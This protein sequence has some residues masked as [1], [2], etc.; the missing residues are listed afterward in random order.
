MIQ[1]PGVQDIPEE[2]LVTDPDDD[3]VSEPKVSIKSVVLP[4]LIGLGT[5]TV[6]GI[7]TFDPDAYR[8][9]WESLN[10]L[11]LA[12][13]AVCVLLRILFGGMRLSYVS[14]GRLSFTGGL[15]GQM[16]WDF[17]ANITPSLVGGAPLAAYYIA[18]SAGEA[19]GRKIK[20]GEVTAFMMFIMLL[21]QAWFALSVIPILISALFLEV[22]PSS[23]GTAGSL[24]A[25]IYFIGFMGWT[26]L[27]AYATFFRPSLL[28]AITDNICRLPFLRR[29]RDRVRHEMEEYDKRAAILR[30]QP[31]LF[32]VQGLGLTGLT[33]IA[34]Y[35][36]VVFIV[37]SFVPHVD[38]LLLFLRSMAMTIGT[39]IMPTPGGAGGVEGLYVLFFKSLM[40]DAFIAPTLLIW[41]ILGYYIFLGF[42]ILITTHHMHMR[43]RKRS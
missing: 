31:F 16:A 11:I 12:G 38:Q 14:R 6:I 9:M 27:F 30:Q 26:A 24:T 2:I 23:A 3:S 32:F 34:R 7:F 42:G 41:R 13:A 29:F 25:I 43:L 19:D 10:P 36:L 28:A 15:R 1:D 5:V 17:A 37:W 21:D 39:L 18:K 22:I 20:M 33:W 35:A 4:L 8:A 40:P